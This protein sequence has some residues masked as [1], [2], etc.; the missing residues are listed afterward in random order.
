MVY[1][2]RE[3]AWAVTKFGSGA[4]PSSAPFDSEVLTVVVTARFAGRGR[5]KYAQ[6]ENSEAPDPFPG[7][8]VV[9]T[10]G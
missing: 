5:V 6:T 4:L 3:L 9:R 7:P 8:K 2:R 10:A 1:T